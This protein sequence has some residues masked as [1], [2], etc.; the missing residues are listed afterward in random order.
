MKRRTDPPPSTVRDEIIGLGSRSL[1]KS[2]YG[3][4]QRSAADAAR[5]RALLDDVSDAI[6]VAALP[7]LRIVDAN[8]AARRLIGA[9]GADPRGRDLSTLLPPPAWRRLRP[10]LRER[11]GTG[12]PVLVRIGGRR[13]AELE[14]AIREEAFGPDR[15]VVLVARDVTERRRALRAIVEAKRAAEA[16]ARA[17]SE[18]LSIA[19]HELRTPLTTLQLRLQ[20][21]ARAGEAAPVVGALLGAVRRLTVIVNDLVEVARAER[22]RL[23][24]KL[25][26]TDLRDL[27]LEHVS[28]LRPAARDRIVRVHSAPAARAMADPDRVLQI[29]ANVLDNAL[30][31]SPRD[32]AVE[33]LVG[34]D[35][36]FA[37][38][39]VADHGPGIAPADR[40][41][42]FT[43]FSR[44]PSARTIPGLGLGLHVSRQL[45]RAQGGDLTVAETPG[46]GATFTLSLPRAEVPATDGA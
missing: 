41:G 40:E 35:V 15:Y 11:A 36:R 32:R 46:G 13:G 9:G 23:D 34:E 4:L 29:L 2:Y 12:A 33:V 10:H 30:K 20:Q 27:A 6:L 44:L 24:V 8:R 14:V 21:A 19:S 42:L 22:G 45:A 5:F 18:F 28:E 31:Y 7:D 26:A 16:L 38:I 43:P 25:V 37:S 17:K 3:P 39:A 1:R